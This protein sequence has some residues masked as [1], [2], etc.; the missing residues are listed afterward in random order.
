MPELKKYRIV[1]GK[2]ATYNERRAANFIATNIRLVTGLKLDIV[3]DDVAPADYELVIGVTERERT[4]NVSFDRADEK[5]WE[6]ELRYVGTRLYITGLGITNDLESNPYRAYAFITDGAFGTSYAS[7]HFVEKILG[8]N[9]VYVSSY[10]SMVDRDADEIRIDES[11]N[12][13]YTAEKLRAER[14][15]RFSGAAMY[16]LPATNSL[17]LPRSCLIFKTTDGKFIVYG[18]GY[19]EDTERL[20]EILEYLSEGKKPVVSAWLLSYIN[21]EQSGVLCGLCENSELAARISVENIYCSILSEEF[22][23]EKAT[24]KNPEYKQIEEKVLN[25]TQILG[26]K[27]HSVSSG[28]EIKLGEFEVDVIR[29]PENIE[30]LPKVTVND[31][32]VVYKLKYN[33]EQSIMLFGNGHKYTSD[34]LVEAHLEELKS[35]V[36]IVGN[37]GRANLSRKCYEAADAKVYICQTSNKLWYGDNGEG[38]GSSN[39]AI[40]RTRTY[41][42]ELG[43]T[44]DNIYCNTESILSFE[45]PIKEK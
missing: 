14:P 5:L 23:T 41:I 32:S 7:Y 17:E 21:P 8:Y 2:N 30:D 26:A 22:Y 24:D 39:G 13:L 28:D 4:E 37:N 33:G 16:A 25:I 36:V 42:K 18:G 43:A 29:A 34:E 9:F 10:D 38:Q 45:L 3:T 40:Q 1:V 12:Y 31:S 27:I 35:D 19:A 20:V 15:E 44:N 11:C 6:S